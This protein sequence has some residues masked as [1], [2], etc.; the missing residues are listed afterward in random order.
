MDWYVSQYTTYYTEERRLGEIGKNI[1]EYNSTFPIIFCVVE[2]I[3]IR[4]C[5]EV[6]EKSRDIVLIKVPSKKVVSSKEVVSNYY[7]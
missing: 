2:C 3:W 7:G 5:I 6:V 4:H 1:K